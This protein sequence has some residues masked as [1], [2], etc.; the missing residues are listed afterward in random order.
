MTFLE[1]YQTYKTIINGVLLIFTF[2]F[3]LECTYYVILRSNINIFNGKNDYYLVLLKDKT[4]KKWQY[5]FVQKIKAD[6]IILA[7]QKA[8]ILGFDMIDNGG[9]YIMFDKID[10]NLY[11]NV[12]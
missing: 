4:A 10:Y 9:K 7:E 11:F 6:N 2:G 1:F 8:S 5:S 12:K 3:L